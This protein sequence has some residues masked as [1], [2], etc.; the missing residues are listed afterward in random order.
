MLLKSLLMKKNIFLFLLFTFS[1]FALVTDIYKEV[2]AINKNTKKASEQDEY[3]SRSIQY[4]APNDIYTEDFEGA[5][6]WLFANGLNVNKWYVDMAVNNG[7]TK[8]LYISNN[9][10][11]ANQYN[12]AAAS[13]SHA[14]KDIAIPANT[15][16]VTFSFDWR[17][18]GNDQS[19]VFNVWIVPST[20][21]P[22][23]G[24]QIFAGADRVH[25]GGPFGGQS[26]WNNYS[27]VVNLSAYAGQN[28]RLVFQWVNIGWEGMQTPA[29]I[30]NILLKS[31]TC[32]S[33]SNIN[34]QNITTT[35]AQISWTAPTTTNVTSYDYYLSQTNIIAP[36]TLPTGNVTTASVN[37]GNLIAGTQYY[38]WVRS[39]CSSLDGQSLWTG[40]F[41]F[42]T[43]CFILNL[44]FTE[45]FNSDSSTVNCWSIIN[46]NNDNVK[47]KTNVTTLPF[48]GDKSA[49]IPIDMLAMTMNDDYL[50]SPVFNF[51]GQYRLKYYY[52]MGWGMAPQTFS[53]KMS[54]NGG[55][56]VSDFTQ[57]LVAEQA[58]SNTQYIEKIVYL[59]AFT[60]QGAFAWYVGS[61]N[62]RQ[63]YIDKVVIE[64]VP[65][66]SEPYEVLSTQLTDESVSVA[67]QQ[68]GTAALWE[69]IVLPHGQSIPDDLTTVTVYQTTTNSIAIND[70]ESNTDYDIYV[71]AVCSPVE[72]SDWSVKLEIRT[73]PSN[74]EC[75]KAILLTVNPGIECVE[76]VSG[77]VIA[78]TPSNVGG[79][80]WGNPYNDV[81]YEFVAIS[82]N[83]H[84]ELQ[85]QNPATTFI[86]LYDE[87]VCNEQT[88]APIACA[89]TSIYSLMDLT[90]GKTYKLRI[91]SVEFSPSVN[92]NICIRTQVPPIQTSD[93]QYT[94]PELVTDVL[95]NN[96]CATISNI[97]WSTGT[98]FNDVNGIGY[99]NKAY[100]DFPFNDGIILST[101]KMLWARGSA[102]QNIHLGELSW[103]DD[104]Q[105]T[106]YINDYLNEPDFPSFNASVLEFDFVALTNE[107]KFNFLFASNEYGGFQC[108]F[109]DPMAFFLT[110]T[111][112]GVTTNIGVVP[113]TEDPISVSTIRKAL[114]SYV[115]MITGEVMCGDVNPEYFKACYDSAFNG[116]DPLL[117]A[118]NFFGLT[119][120][121]TAKSTVIPGTTY[122]IKLVI[123]DRGHSGLD[124]AVFIEGGS[125]DLG[126]VELGDD[127]LIDTGNAL[128]YGDTYVLDSGLNADSFEIQWYKDNVLIEGAEETTLEITESGEYKI[129]ATIDGGNCTL[130][131]TIKVEIYPEIKIVAP[132]NIEI[133]VF[134]QRIP[135]VDLT[136]NENEML[137]LL[138][139]LSDIEVGYYE[140]GATAELE[141][142]AI[143]D[144]ENYLTS[145]LP[146]EIFVRID[147]AKTGCHRIVSFKLLAK[148]VVDLI[149]PENIVVCLYDGVPVSVD[150][151]SVKS[152]IVS[153]LVNPNVMLYYY[154]TYENAI[155]EVG[156]IAMPQNYV[157]ATLPTT[158][159]IRFN[160]V[161]T[162]CDVMT[163][164]ELVAS[165]ELIP[166]KVDDITICNK[167]ILP[168]LPE[169]YFYSTEEFGQGHIIKSG[170]EYNSG[171]YKIY[172]NIQNS[173][174]CVFS[175]SYTVEVID[176]SIPKG[177]SPNGDQLNDSFDLT[178]YHPSEVVLYNRYG[179]EIYSYGSG[180]TNQW[181]GQNKEG[182]PLPDGTYFYKITVDNEVFT[183]Y[184][185]LVREI[186]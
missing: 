96:P 80:C 81:W 15:S 184:V 59:P 54:Q 165:P 137:S 155:D 68:F 43:N 132:K 139:D 133:C 105:L 1:S 24:F 104:V 10:G 152:D 12:I 7:G 110:N 124:S 102:D 79:L 167:Y 32:S 17:S 148:E 75:D 77:T 76:S 113:G 128:C 50:I 85:L 126:N 28:I 74:D 22:L 140:T 170:A 64:P 112:T 67:W 90:V 88:L 154:E 99:F 181:Y 91:Y 150:L 144:P 57:T 72:Q 19:D 92:F 9:N 168:K 89:P 52:A 53:V 162:S 141:E 173:H 106:T 42:F 175:S 178:Y 66:C 60:G 171:L 169:D 161:A 29:A 65:L 69:V 119:V 177:I 176:C 130:T 6:N 38:F 34:V 49:N 98:N 136:F 125:F 142:E 33:P 36:T 31:V 156:A 14:Y 62:K 117:S 164:V 129:E 78:A 47:W 182:K 51:N 63:I 26:I 41:S 13:I 84:V 20:F 120:P 45:T 48:E 157:P 159:Y 58:Y 122:H 11:V 73:P 147:N 153:Q 23:S 127:L 2:I 25:V 93:T 16:D 172:I 5:H 160:D 151:T 114:H 21:T 145:E 183:G 138:S 8:A 97:T 83:Q 158:I 39:N 101:G 146:K 82:E 37:V 186:K 121:M 94:V 163:S 123:Q 95:I 185:Q 87:D 4:W 109:R 61:S 103:P 174:G 56:G 44:P 3:R 135:T 143:T 27:T 40:P 179:M 111:A 166:V 46:N 180:Y 30:D 134:T 70:I 86:A 55:I 35:D 115:D 118:V 108:A 149:P 107:L 100:S 71:R 116:Q 18:M 131:G